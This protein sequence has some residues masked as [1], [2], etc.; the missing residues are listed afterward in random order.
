MDGP[1]K[2]LVV[3]QDQLRDGPRAGVMAH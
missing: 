3:L 1:I 2:P